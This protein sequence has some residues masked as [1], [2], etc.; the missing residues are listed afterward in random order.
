MH[1]TVEVGERGD[2]DAS[3]HLNSGD[4]TTIFASWGSRG[5]SAMMVPTC[6]VDASEHDTVLSDVKVR[7]LCPTGFEPATA[8]KAARCDSVPAEKPT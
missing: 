5:Y 2:P 7:L 6:K 1:P 3:S 8:A 4:A